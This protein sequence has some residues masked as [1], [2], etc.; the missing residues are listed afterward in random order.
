MAFFGNDTWLIICLVKH[1]QGHRDK[2]EISRSF[3]LSHN[4]CI[5][6]SEALWNPFSQLSIQSER[7]ETRSQSL[8]TFRDP[9][10]FIEP[11]SC[12]P[13]S[14]E[15]H[16]FCHMFSI[17]PSRFGMS[18]VLAM[19]MYHRPSRLF[20]PFETSW[21]LCASVWNSFK[22]GEITI[23]RLPFNVWNQGSEP[24]A[25]RFGVNVRF[26]HHQLDSAKNFDSTNFFT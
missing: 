7:T 21:G 16:L 10:A 8:Y 18:I 24:E 20:P 23:D 22:K 14:P 19:V 6:K 2:G 17:F 15:V 5:P 1:K 25:K 9:R 12:R 3:S 13:S 26:K 11:R 4:S